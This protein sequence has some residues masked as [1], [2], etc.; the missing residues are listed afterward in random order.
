MKFRAQPRIQKPC[1]KTWDSL[2]GN[3]QKRFCSVCQHFVHNLDEMTDEE[4]RQVLRAPGRKCVA[5]RESPEVR[6]LPIGVWLF[7][8]R[9]RL[10]RPITALVAVLVALLG[11][12]CATTNRKDNSNCPP[13]LADKTNAPEKIED[14]KTF[15]TVGIIID[16]TPLWKR[17]LHIQ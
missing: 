7:L 9:L 6:H 12:G 2:T 16:D 3:E 8:D 1:P 13:T 17:I 5:Y 15:T 10:L 4:C 14:G 11:T